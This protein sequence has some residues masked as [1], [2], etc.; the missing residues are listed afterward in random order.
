M[1]K[2]RAIIGAAALAAAC[3]SGTAPRRRPG[4]TTRRPSWARSPRCSVPPGFTCA[5]RATSRRMS[6]RQLGQAGAD[7]QRDG[8]RG[9]GRHRLPRQQ[10]PGRGRRSERRP[11]RHVDDM[12]G[13]TSTAVW[14]RSTDGGVTWPTPARVFVAADRTPIGNPVAN[15]D[16][17]TLNAPA[18][19]GEVADVFPAVAVGPDGHVYFGSYRGTVV[20]PWQTCAAGPPP[21]VVPRVLDRHE[22]PPDGGVVLRR[23]VRPDTDQPGGR[24]YRVRQALT[25]AARS[26]GRRTTPSATEPRPAPGKWS[27]ARV[28]NR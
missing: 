9:A 25:Q 18:D 7:R 27:G 6:R 24:R 19:P 11:V 15:P 28:T 17:T 1:K 13:E 21:P 2:K 8:H 23:R 3:S 4:R 26:G 16:G 20:S 10:L 22:Q 5:S 12:V 14:S